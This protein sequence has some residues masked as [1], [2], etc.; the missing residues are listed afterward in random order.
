MYERRLFNME[1]WPTTGNFLEILI[2]EDMLTRYGVR[3]ITADEERARQI[4]AVK[5]FR[6]GK[7]SYQAY[8]TGGVTVNPQ[9]LYN[10]GLRLKPGM[11]QVS[12]Q[13]RRLTEDELR[14]FVSISG[15]NDP[16]WNHQQMSLNT[17]DIDDAYRRFGWTFF[18]P[19]NG[20]QDVQLNLVTDYGACEFMKV[21]VR[22]VDFE[23][24]HIREYPV[25]SETGVGLFENVQWQGNAFFASQVR[26]VEP[27]SG[28]DLRMKAAEQ[29]LFNPHREVQWVGPAVKPVLPKQLGTGRILEWEQ[30]VNRVRA[31]VEVSGNPALFVLPCGYDAGWSAWQDG[32]E[33]RVVPVD[34]ISRGVV[35]EE[36]KHE[37]SLV[38]WPNVFVVGGAVTAFSLLI[39]TIVFASGLAARSV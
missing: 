2:R 18:V 1:L 20:E 27:E 15:I 22:G 28:S 5:E 21:W 11:Y 36:G 24:D 26:V 25:K 23:A 30:S 19:G 37:I 31:F 3:F 6:G 16:L 13:A 4:R 32:L 39:L 9:Q 14:L 29:V 33:S 35:V 38:Y 17:W 12:F 10:R 34:G 8:L 7:N